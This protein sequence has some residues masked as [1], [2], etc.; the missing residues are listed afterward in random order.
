MI[1]IKKSNMK[2]NLSKSKKNIVVDCNK[3][4]V[5]KINN[6]DTISNIKP[7]KL[8]KHD[9]IFDI[10]YLKS[11]FYGKEFMTDVPKYM[12]R[13]FYRYSNNK[14]FFDNGITFECLNIEEAKGKI[15]KEYVRSFTIKTGERTK[16]KEIGLKNY[17]EH[18]MFLS[19]PEA[20]L[21]INYDKPSIFTKTEHIRGFEQAYSYLNMKK[22][23]PRNY[24]RKIEMTDYVKEGVKM[25]FD[26][27]KKV[28]CS[29]DE[30]EYDT[31][32][33]FLSSSACGHK[34]KI[35]LLW[36]S[37]E[38]TGKGTVLNFMFDLLGKRMYKTTDAEQIEK[39]TKNF[40]GCT[41]LNLDEM[42]SHGIHKTFQDKMKGLITEPKFD[43][44][45]MYQQSYIQENTFNLILTSNN[46]CVQLTQSNEIRYF[47]NT[48]SHDY[49]GNKEYFDK[50]HKYLYNEDVKVAIYQEFVR[51]FEEQ[52]KPTNWIGNNVRATTAGKLKRIEALPLFHKYIKDN[53]LAH[54]IGIDEESTVFFDKYKSHNKYDSKHKVGRLLADFGVKIKKVNPGDGEKQYRKYEISFKELHEMFKKN[55]W[56]DDLVDE[57]PDKEENIEYDK[58][59]EKECD[60][61]DKKVNLKPQEKI[62]NKDKKKKSKNIITDN[63]SILSEEVIESKKI[64]LSELKGKLHE[65]ES[66]EDLISSLEF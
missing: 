22:D 3:K 6:K 34:V 57:I 62:K 53:Y 29:N 49:I 27:I 44:R 28:I 26:H 59:F 58:E 43:C 60:D 8:Q 45:Q 37:K 14:I 20:R 33:K 51:I 36:Q 54:G 21:T 9:V 5:S 24:N 35:C 46:N 48:I 63:N 18:E 23:L 16:G 17:F 13:F 4:N 19:T 12:N 39:Y 25:F 10:L 15:P 52:V 40:E 30:Y 66:I 31:T 38:Q 64:K 2:F 41:L 50:L 65:N 56:I 7:P 32:V 61:W 1:S 11:L 42:S 55:N 47:V